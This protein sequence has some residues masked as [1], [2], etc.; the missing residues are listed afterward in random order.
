LKEFGAAGVE[1][2]KAELGQLHERVGFKAV[3]IRELTL[4]EKIRAQEGLML[5]TQNPPEARRAV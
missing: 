4:V 3:A 1:A 5:L 2:C